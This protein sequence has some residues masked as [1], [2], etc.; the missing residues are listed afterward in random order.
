[1]EKIIVLVAGG[2]VIDVLT[3]DPTRVIIVDYDVSEQN[4]PNAEFCGEMAN[5]YEMCPMVLDD[6]LSGE[7]DT[8][9]EERVFAN[10]EWL[11]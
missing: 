1:M 6:K 9:N 7:L 3:K 5:M 11:D 8:F 2:T 4:E 10:E